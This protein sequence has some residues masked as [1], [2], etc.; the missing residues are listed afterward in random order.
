MKLKRG[1]V[2]Y[3]WHTL[4]FFR[5][6]RKRP[7]S[8]IPFKRDTKAH[9]DRHYRFNRKTD[10]S[11]LE[12]IPEKMKSRGNEFWH[13]WGPKSKWKLQNIEKLSIFSLK[14]FGVLIEMHNFGTR[15]YMRFLTFFAKRKTQ[16]RQMSHDRASKQRHPNLKRNKKHLKK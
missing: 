13:K 4:F 11:I 8:P 5:K 16:R 1:C 3:F 14:N 7:F 6:R 15:N 9:S 2:R 12:R 10:W